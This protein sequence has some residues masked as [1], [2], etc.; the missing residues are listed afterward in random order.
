MGKWVADLG[1]GNHFF[2]PMDAAL[3]EKLLGVRSRTASDPPKLAL[4]G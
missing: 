4:A 2:E 3:V 1:K